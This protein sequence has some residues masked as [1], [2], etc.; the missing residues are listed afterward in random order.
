MVS[1]LLSAQITFQCSRLATVNRYLCKSVA[2][3]QYYLW[4][5]VFT[6]SMLLA[7]NLSK[8]FSVSYL[9]MVNPSWNLKQLRKYCLIAWLVPLLI[10]SA[11]MC[12]DLFADIGFAYGNNQSEVCWLVGNKSMLF[13]FGVPVGLMLLVNVSLFIKTCFSLQKYKKETKPA[14]QEERPSIW[15][16]IITLK[17]AT[18]LGFTWIFGIVARLTEQAAL[19]YAFNISNSLQGIA[20]GLAFGCNGTT[21]R[22]WKIFIKND[23]A[24]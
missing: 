3:L 11:C 18:L 2:V 10:V 21:L 1:A 14:A 24:V 6:W 15:N 16:V 23:V 9:T 5:S 22:Q 8:S 20:I 7:W 19:W 12:L 17:I 13:G 4:L